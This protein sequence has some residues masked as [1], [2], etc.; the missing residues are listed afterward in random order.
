MPGISTVIWICALLA[1]ALIGVLAGYLYRKNIA[2]KEIGSAED[3]ATRIINEAIKSAEA[4]KRE[5]LVEAKEEIYR[6]KTEFDRETKERNQDIKKQE[7]RILQKEEA[8]D[9]KYESMEQ[10]EEKLNKK[11]KENEELQE[12]IRSVKKSQLEML[13]KIS[14][15]TV[16]EAKSIIIS[17]IEDDA[18]HD[19][20]V[21]L[22]EIERQLKEDSD[23]MAR[24]V[25]SL[26]RRSCKRSHRVCRAAAQRRDEG[27]D[28][29]TRGTQYQDP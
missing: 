18:R 23:K 10:K 3:E 2:E 19:A 6:A 28:H 5:A 7:R 9:R 14:G 21:K 16:E 29:R 24:E 25:I 17:Q 13:E 27:Q 22:K 1:A 11:L 20:A 12:E 26:R 8:I 15:M 4:K